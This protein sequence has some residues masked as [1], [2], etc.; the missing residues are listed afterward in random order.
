[1]ISLGIESTAHTFG[2]GMITDNGKVL[3]DEKSV[4]TPPIGSG[5]HPRMAA[6]F[7]I[8]NAIRTLKN[9]LKKI[10]SAEIDLIAFSQGPGLPNCLNVGASIARYLS[11]KYKKPLIGVN[12]CVA[13]IEIGKIMTGCKDP[14]IVYCSGGNTQIIA[15]IGGRYRIFGE[16]EDIPIGNAFDVLARRM[17]LKMPGGPKIE[18]HAET[19]KWVDLPYVVK[20]MDLS[21]AGIVT[22]CIKRF[23]EG[24]KIEN[25]S[26]S[27]QET[28][29]SMLTEVTERAMAH[30]NKNEVLI[31][32]G[33]AASRKLKNMMKKMCRQREGKCYVVP[34]E[35]AGDN[36]AMI[37]WNGILAYKS[38][39]QTNI[40]KSEIRKDWR[41][42][43]VDVTWL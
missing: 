6:Q 5:I 16:T 39:Q 21:F 17:G 12:H 23:E 26:Y 34:K 20:G 11:L 29:Y 22:E 27:F 14:V 1:M 25:I 33:V 32:G 19:G 28:V 31:T 2:V 3:V 40:K 38:K 24:E 13:H 36:G 43:E 42:D 7:H 10:K 30:T 15:F 41:T 37:G 18:K 4:Y 9:V 8:E 35:F